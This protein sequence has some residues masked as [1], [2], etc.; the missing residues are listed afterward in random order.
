MRS[1]SA[2]SSD[3][4]RVIVSGA[5]GASST[6]ITKKSKPLAASANA[7]GYPSSRNTTSAANMMGA[8]FCATRWA[9]GEGTPKNAPLCLALDLDDAARPLLLAEIRKKPLGLGLR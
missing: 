9:M 1:G 8:R 4:D 2:C 6:A 3:Q 7:T 5:N